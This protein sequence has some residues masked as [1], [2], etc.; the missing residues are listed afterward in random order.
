MQVEVAPIDYSGR[1]RA[2]VL[3]IIG[4]ISI[5]FGALV[6]RLIQEADAFQ[7]KLLSLDIYYSW[8][9]YNPSFSA[10]CRSWHL[11]I[12]ELNIFK[13]IAILLALAGISFLQA[14]TNTTVAATTFTLSVIPF[15]T[16]GLAWLILKESLHKK[17]NYGRIDFCCTGNIYYDMDPL[18]VD[19]FMEI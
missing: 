15:L 16:A 12:K 13:W 4:S 9:F 8:Y 5:S 2:I 7:S 1:S 6:I 18:I 14:I 17:A 10:P 11:K 19:H 3:M